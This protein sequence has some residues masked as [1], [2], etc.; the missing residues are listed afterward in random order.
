MENLEESLKETS[1]GIKKDFNLPGEVKTPYIQTLDEKIF[2]YIFNEDKEFSNLTFDSILYEGY[3]IITSIRF[4][5]NSISYIISPLI[6]VDIEKTLNNIK[7][8]K[9]EINKINKN[10]RTKIFSM[11]VLTPIYLEMKLNIEF[12]DIHPHVSAL[13]KLIKFL[14]RTSYEKIFSHSS[15]GIYLRNFLG[16]IS[17]INY[18]YEELFNEFSEFYFAKK[19]KEM[20]YSQLVPEDY[21][22]KE[23]D[24]KNPQ[25]Y[26]KFLELVKPI[27]KPIGLNPQGKYNTTIFTKSVE[28]YLNS[29][30]EV[31]LLNIFG[32]EE[33]KENL[34]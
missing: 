26:F 34:I 7:Y 12:Q 20:N 14:Y 21:L 13:N 9:F 24:F 18:F 3:S 16:K 28:D 4:K 23:I 5:N 33:P 31:N 17:A 1:E 32:F 11:F 10:D 6:V 2:K 25:Q 27:F 30:S 29:L 15:E 8:K 22:K 19:L